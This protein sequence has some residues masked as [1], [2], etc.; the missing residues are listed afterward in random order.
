[1][2]RDVAFKTSW[3]PVDFGPAVEFLAKGARL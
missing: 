2:D 3:V 1:M